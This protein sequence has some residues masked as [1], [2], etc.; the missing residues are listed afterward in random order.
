[1]DQTWSTISRAIKT[2]LSKY[3]IHL[4]IFNRFKIKP[5]NA[6]L[7]EQKVT[8]LFCHLKFEFLCSYFKK[9]TWN[10]TSVYIYP[11][12]VWDD[13]GIKNALRK[14]MHTFE[15]TICFSKELNIFI[16]NYSS[17]TQRNDTEYFKRFRII[18]VDVFIRGRIM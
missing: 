5:P 18:S 8:V 15:T 3:F 12:R 13:N 7:Y 4:I 6:R 10:Y 14:S 17:V 11:I 1:M 2:V 9:P 16:S